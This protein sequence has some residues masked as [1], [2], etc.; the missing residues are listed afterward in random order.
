MRRQ[1]GSAA[2]TAAA[3]A[4]TAAATAA[5]A[6]PAEA[7]KAAEATALH[8]LLQRLDM[9]LVVAVRLLRLGEHACELT[10][11]GRLAFGPPPL[12][13][14]RLLRLHPS[15]HRRRR[16]IHAATPAGSS[17]SA[18]A[19]ASAVRIG[20]GVDAVDLEELAPVVL[21]RLLHRLEEL[22]GL[23]HLR[24]LLLLAR[25]FERALHGLLQRRVR[26]RLVVLL[27]AAAA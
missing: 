1:R 20:L 5:A 12:A 18:S 26:R 23:L 7:A 22:L 14:R 27:P 15:D 6:A 8:L 11:L 19:S 13:L 24:R 3:A 16:R 2:A 9:E 25:E 4:A 21:P 17:A 10:L